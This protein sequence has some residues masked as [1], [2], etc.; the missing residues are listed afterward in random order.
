MFLNTLKVI[1][2]MID[3]SRVHNTESYSVMKFILA[4][5]SVLY[6]LAMEIRSV[7]FKHRRKN[8]LPGF[9]ISVGNLTVGGTGKTP[10]VLMIAEWACAEGYR[11]AILSRG[12]GGRYKQEILE[13]TDGNEIFAGPEEAGD[14]PFL[15]A[16]R[17][18]NIP[19]VVSKNRYKAG[20]YANRKFGSDFFVLD[21]GYQY[22]LLD[23]DLDL[24]LMDS[25]NPVGNGRLLPL[26]P[27]REPIKCLKR[28]DAIILTRWPEGAGTQNVFD[29][30]QGGVIDKPV[31]K[32]RHIP[33]KLVFPN[34][35]G[36]F[37]PGYLKNRRIVAFAGIAKPIDF[38]KALLDLESEVLYFKSFR[39]H[40]P[41]TTD[42]FK[43][44]Y[45]KVDRLGAD[46][47]V[48]T[49]KDWGRVEKIARGY[50]G[51]AYLSIRFSLLGNDDVFFG[52]I[53]KIKE[54]YNA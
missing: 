26:G 25:S 24:L 50:P 31:F 12:Y 47:I 6:R 3:W 45:E 48:T 38:R 21:D 36:I 28:A 19:V 22:I 34:D 40:H 17:L 54:T 44:L 16:K 41:F 43:D 11:T 7:I 5:F 29:F 1:F 23:R 39:D 27:L 18:N 46:C 13:V 10:A 37:N 30:I 15:L 52:M 9:V 53:K 35:D 20:L 51:V 8:S 42:E 32:S 33:D 49:E 14:E 4:F 2:E